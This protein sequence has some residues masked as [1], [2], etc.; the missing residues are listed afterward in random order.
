MH[1]HAAS[2]LLAS[3]VL[4]AGLPPR[5]VLS[6]DVPPTTAPRAQPQNTR[7]STRRQQIFSEAYSASASG[8]YYVNL[9]SGVTYRVFVDQSGASVDQ[10]GRTSDTS[11]AGLTITPRVSSLP[12]IRF[13]STMFSGNNGAAFEAPATT[14]YKVET[15]Y[16]GREAIIVRIYR[17]AVDAYS[18]ACVVDPTADGCRA[19]TDV[20]T[21][22][23][24]SVSP[25]V[26]IMIG[27][28]PLLF[29]GMMRNGRSF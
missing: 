16:R 2:S 22:P 29:V 28:L 25:A 23:R 26:L 14:G 27:V 7:G 1:P 18:A 19:A 13:S 17:E 15:F 20:S 3:L 8:P 21:R 9:D 10:R 12:P 24:T 4:L 6:Q 5:P 11:S